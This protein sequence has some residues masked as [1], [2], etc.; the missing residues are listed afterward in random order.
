MVQIGKIFGYYEEYILP[1][2]INIPGAFWLERRLS[3]ILE[4]TEGRVEKEPTNI[5]DLEWDNLIILDACRY[6][7]YS[8]LHPETDF[9]YS[10]GSHSS[11]FISKTFSK[12]DFSDIVYVTGNPHFSDEE[13]KKFTNREVEDTFHAIYKTFNTDW[14]DGVK[15]D[16]IIRDTKNAQK[17][18]P[19]KKKIIHFMQ[20]HAP[21]IGYD[22]E[23][24]KKNVNV[25]NHSNQTEAYKKTL[26]H[27][28][29]KIQPLIEELSGKT[30]ITADHGELLGEGGVYHL[31]VMDLEVEALRKV[32]WHVVKDQV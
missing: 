25:P 20:P 9:I 10:V 28:D 30:V 32:P 1:Y 3:K 5:F 15:P 29:E 18:F 21:Y 6:D 13:F 17:L 24:V 14:D 11:E 22:G 23:I 4:L 12:G 26:Q 27:I 7:Y 31:H 8:E 16:P 19:D 2:I